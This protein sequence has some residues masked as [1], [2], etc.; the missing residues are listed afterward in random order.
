MAYTSMNLGKNGRHVSPD[1][2]MILSR[3]V[4]GVLSLCLPWGGRRSCSSFWVRVLGHFLYVSASMAAEPATCEMF[5]AQWIIV[6]YIII[7]LNFS[8][9]TMHMHYN[10]YC[11]GFELLLCENW[12]N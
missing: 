9:F 7:I 2:S 12:L 1:W 10:G 8:L 6:G 11:R 4:E 5:V 3:G